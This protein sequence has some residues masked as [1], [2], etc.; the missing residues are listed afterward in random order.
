MARGGSSE[1]TDRVQVPKQTRRLFLAVALLT[2][3]VYLVTARGLPQTFDEQII[4]DTTSSLAHGHASIDTPLLNQ[5]A[6]GV[7]RSDG[8]QAGI[9]GIGT[10]AVGVPL[11]A[12]GKVVAEISPENNRDQIVLTATM[13]TDA[14]ITAAAVFM[15]ML[16]CFL[17]GAP[18]PGAVLVG[19]S[20]GLGSYAYP[21][22]LTLFTEPGTALCVIAAVYY[23]IRAARGAARRDLIA[24]GAFAGGALL[25]RVSAALFVPLFGLW[26]L[27]AAWRR[28]SD[29][30]PRLR[31]TFEFGAWYTAGV[32]GPL[33]IVLATNAWRYGSPTNFGYALG[34]ATSQ[35]YP[36]VR[37]VWN[38]WF[39]SG[40]S[41]FLF[42][43]IAVIAVAGLVRSFRKLPMEMGLL[44]ALVIV[45]TLFFARVQFW[46]GDWAWGPRYLQIVIPCI[47]AM[48]APLMDS[49]QWRRAL[50]GASVL[51][52]LFAALPA[53]L[54]RF[55][56]VWHAAYAAMPPASPAGPPVWDHS[57]YALVWHTAHW[58]QI[59]YQLRLLSDAW[60]NSLNH[61][62]SPFGP[63]GVIKFPEPRF[64]IWWLRVRD[65]GGTAVFV[66]AWAPVIVA[67]AGAQL[68][69]SARKTSPVKP[70]D[71]LEMASE[72]GS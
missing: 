65:L 1:P 13:F 57:Y 29:A 51:G 64:E 49:P 52:L 47:A 16:V 31:R 38:Q 70:S 41:V 68:L 2:L 3:A 43:P 7:K 21:H 20:F 48:A 10:S 8:R 18:P 34:T 22:A 24:C 72:T 59:G 14:F 39:S 62:T 58:Q 56:I 9:Y 35:S 12:I 63:T 71:T 27:L 17:L 54:V 28:T 40:K 37:G 32:I 60:S 69:R 19:L 67:G 4:F 55:T 33:V 42:A 15:L 53:V 25:F 36:I 50:L 6:L 30:S 66:F 46:S 61:V 5:F 23:A 11:Y 45:N 26:L 44:A